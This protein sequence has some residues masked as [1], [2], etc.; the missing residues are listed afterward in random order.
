[1]PLWQWVVSIAGRIVIILIE[2]TGKSLWRPA[3]GSFLPF[4]NVIFTVKSN[5]SGD[6]KAQ[7]TLSSLKQYLLLRIV[8]GEVL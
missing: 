1:M 2:G 7:T 5:L 8:W 4:S 3:T 6:K